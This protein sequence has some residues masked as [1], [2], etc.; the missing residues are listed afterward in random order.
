MAEGE[1]IQTGLDEDERPQGSLAEGEF[2][3][4]AMEEEGLPQGVPFEG[5]LTEGQVR[6]ATGG[7]AETLGSALVVEVTDRHPARAVRSDRSGR[8][9][10]ASAGPEYGRGLYLVSRLSE[11]W[12]ITYR[13]GSKTVWARIGVEAAT[14]HRSLPHLEAY[15]IEQTLQRGLSAADILA[16]V[17]RG[18]GKDHERA[19]ADWGGRGA[20]GFLAEASDLLAGQLDEN[21]V[22]ALACQLL[23]P[24]LA[25][26][27]AVW[28]DEEAGRGR[29]PGGPV[30]ATRL[31]RVWHSRENHT[32][33]LRRR[34]E[35]EPPPLPA[36]PRRGPLPAPW[37]GG[38]G[39]DDASGA[40]LVHR[41]TAAGTAYG[42]L[43]IG[44][45]GLI[46]YP[47][48]ITGLVE[49]FGRRVAFAIGTA[50]QYRSQ[51]SISQI[52]QRG[53]LPYG[54][55]Q[56]PGVQQGLVYEPRAGGVAGGDFYDVFPAGDGRWCFVL[57]DVQ[58]NGPEAAVVTG[59]VRPWL[60]LLAREGYP[61]A[62]LLDRLNQLLMEDAAEAA[63]TAA[64]A[65]AEADGREAPH[66]RSSS[67]FLS[68]LYGELVPVAGGVRCVVAC[69]GHPLPLVLRPDGT[70]RS[71][72]TS[73]MLLG[74]VEDTEFTSD[75]FELLA[76]DTL[77]CVT[78]GVTE[79]RSDR[80]QFDDG[81]G[82][83]TALS[84]CAGLSAPLVADRIRRLVHEFAEEPPDDDLALLVLQAQVQTRSRDAVLAM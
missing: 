61:V 2:I 11:S 42:T 69:A 1:L 15:A 24:R 8:P 73:Q 17:P 3:R 77:L 38:E 45:A 13:T 74:V 21:L 57:G 83:S 33:A 72:A 58:G 80:R 5:E 65:A 12:G 10:S 34:L 66:E 25:D 49:D 43:M 46:R 30:D 52:L 71:V 50:R 63:E 6:G 28:L 68:L 27:C 32:E 56:I 84:S 14:G 23:V 75:S 36:D 54:M 29:M 9:S 22:A 37:P 35:K 81:D 19:V 55:P 39:A 47:D 79:R 18:V 51:A 44:R 41:L 4:A 48:E 7:S 59:L 70:V 16:P 67:R 78:D 53:L 20:L 82:L 64:R 26:W 60:R 62:R 40:A 76:G 31:A